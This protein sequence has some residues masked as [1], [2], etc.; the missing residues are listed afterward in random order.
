MNRQTS[1]Y[2]DLVRV[3][4]ALLVFLSH[5]AWQQSSGGLLWQLEYYGRDAV[6]VFFVLSGFVIAFAVDGREA[7]ART[8]AV[9]RAARIYSV[10]LP[11]LVATFALDAL[12][13]SLRPDLYVTWCCDIAGNAAWQFLGSALFLNEI[14]SHHAP[15]GSDVPYWSLGYEVIYYAVFGLAWFVRRPWNLAAAG[16][17]LVVAGPGIAALFPLW[18]LGAAAYRLCARRP[19]G[20]GVGA[21]LMVVSFAGL[22]ANAVWRQR[23]GEIYAP[24][25]LTS[26]RLRDYGQDYLVG[27]LF[28]LNLIGFRGLSSG[29]AGGW[30]RLARPIRWLAG[31]TFTLY[32]FHQP[33]IHVLVAVSPWPVERWETRGMVFLVVPVVVLLLAEVTERRKAV[34]RQAFTALGPVGAGR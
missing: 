28:V 25:A 32:L 34:W 26:E 4:A 18:V 13:R 23:T 11:A 29:L 24:F 30:D 16:L 31:A 20:A 21:A 19:P 22:A 15:P 27:G 14:W 12:G 3:L 5:A 9:N 7:S 2:L 6:D 10:A 33:L 17:L 1:T 8:Y